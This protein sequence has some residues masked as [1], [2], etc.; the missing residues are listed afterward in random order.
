MKLSGVELIRVEV[1]FHR[2][3]GTAA[4]VHR[5]RSLLFARIETTE[6]E[7]WGESAAM[8][9]GTLVDPGV[10]DVERAMAQRGIRRLCDASAA[11]GGELPAAGEIVPLFGTTPVDRMMGATFEM[12]VLD[13]ELR[14]AGRSLAE[15]L[16][17]G[18]GFEAM[19]V[20]AAVG[21]PEG[22]D[23]GL[24]RHAVAGQVALGC[25]RLRLK[26]APGWDMEPVRTVREMC[27]E[28]ALQVDANGSYRL[29]TG[30]GRGSGGGGVDDPASADGLAR[31]ADWGVLCVE[32]PLP[33]ADLAAHAELGRRLGVPICLDE[34]LT[35]PR[36]VLD[37]LRYGACQV[38]CLKPGRLGGLGAARQAHAACVDA[39]VPV[40]VGGFFEAGLGRAANLALAASLA[41]Q[42]VGL[43]G[44]LGDPSS[45]LAIDPCGYPAVRL[46]WVTVPV[47]AGVGPPPQADRLAQLA[48]Q[49]RWFPATYT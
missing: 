7:G 21:I 15:G 5:N 40:F 12:A 23:L 16:G 44:D 39:G 8:S 45:Y 43:V 14:R 29:G 42:A 37:A 46:G 18:P 31:L 25:S 49:R 36:R 41:Q 28:L 38:A 47:H 13:A 33:P 26:I 17:V 27:P 3:I 35:S 11:R 19:P 20:G 10:D 9:A 34:S 48:V 4:G 6:G 22:R 30:S 24:L 2:E 32:Q 1:P